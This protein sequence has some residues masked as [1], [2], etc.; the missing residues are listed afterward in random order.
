MVPRGRIVALD[1]AAPA[2]QVRAIA[3]GTRHARL[4]VY[5]D[6]L[7]NVVGYVATR[8]ILTQLAT[9]GQCDLAAVIRPAHF[10]PEQL[11]AVDV[12][13]DLQRR[14]LPMALV[15]DEQGGLS[16]LV[17]VEDLVEELVGE[18]VDEAETLEATVREEPDG[19]A[20]ALGTAPI[21]EVNRLLDL[22]LPDGP[23]WSTLGGLAMALADGIPQAGRRLRAPDGTELEVLEATPRRVVRVRL[24]PKR[25][26]AGASGPSADGDGR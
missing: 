7:E 25:L 14:R 4:P 12:L 19:R 11:R 13:R 23:S 18:I 5:E 21:H 1:R 10:V 6:G 2:D 8:E 16:G 9:T 17:T 20:T 3:L 24:T 22:D 15:I 26:L